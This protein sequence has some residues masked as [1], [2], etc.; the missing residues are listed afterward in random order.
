[1]PDLKNLVVID[2]ETSGTNPLVH[3]VLS[4]AFVPLSHAR[5]P[6]VIYVHHDDICWTDFAHRNFQNFAHEWKARAVSPKQAVNEVERYLS[7]QFERSVVTPVG[8]NI[9]FDLS[10]LKRLAFQAGRESIEL[11]GHRAIDT[12]T[13]LYLLYL[14]GV[15]PLSATS[16]DGA[17][18]HFGLDVPEHER[19]TAYGD[20]VATRHLFSFLLS[21]FGIGF[22][23]EIIS[24]F[25]L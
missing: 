15:I 20:A 7:I 25:P 2:T 23:R 24:P 9:G 1:M 11:L 16:S 4:L 17:F 10:F 8:H 19:H 3:D 6:L 12:H 22:G 14:K 18:Q 5:A 13:M 21:E